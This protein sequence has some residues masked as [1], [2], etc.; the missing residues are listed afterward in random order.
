M[1]KYK[2]YDTIAILSMLSTYNNSEFSAVS[3]DNFT[4][5]IKILLLIAKL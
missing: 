2:M 3:T 5:Y 1:K 4:L